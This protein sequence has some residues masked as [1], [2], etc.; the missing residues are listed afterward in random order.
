MKA[1]IYSQFCRGF[2]ILLSK[3]ITMELG[4]EKKIIIFGKLDSFG[5]RRLESFQSHFN[6]PI[7]FD[8]LTEQIF[9][10]IFAGDYSD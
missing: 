5:S 1:K 10:D 2:N 6:R 4:S 9:L 3:N 7:I 8:S